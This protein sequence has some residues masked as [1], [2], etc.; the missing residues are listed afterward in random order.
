MSV[1]SF[2]FAVYLRLEFGSPF[3]LPIEHWL[4]YKQI[5]EIFLCFLF[6]QLQ[7]LY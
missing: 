2:P 4:K 7:D 3:S 6:L 1:A 5:I